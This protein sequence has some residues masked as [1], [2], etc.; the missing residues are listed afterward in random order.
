MPMHY[1]QNA[2]PNMDAMKKL[3]PKDG[4]I[5]DVQSLIQSMQAA[6]SYQPGIQQQ[7]PNGGVPGVNLQ[8]ILQGMNRG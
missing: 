8:Q 1:G 7:M 6:G 2:A 4:N 5:V 3:F